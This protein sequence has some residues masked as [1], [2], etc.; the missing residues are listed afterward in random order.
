MWTYF[1]GLALV[2]HFR[3]KYDL[4]ESKR[5]YFIFCKKFNFEFEMKTCFSLDLRFHGISIVIQLCYR[6]Q[7]TTREIKLL[8]RLMKQFN[9]NF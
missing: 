2:F 3:W 4:S 8:N 5:M 1:Q 7:H 6:K 9:G